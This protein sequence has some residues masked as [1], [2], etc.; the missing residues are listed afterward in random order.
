M[1][2]VMLRPV[3][4]KNAMKLRSRTMACPSA[5][6]KLAPPPAAKDALPNDFMTVTL[7]FTPPD[8]RAASAVDAARQSLKL[9]IAGEQSTIETPW[10]SASICARPTPRCRYGRR[11]RLEEV[12]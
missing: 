3:D 2:G 10:T 6:A 5:I 4:G 9:A 12:G 1:D 7:R 8:A 11:V